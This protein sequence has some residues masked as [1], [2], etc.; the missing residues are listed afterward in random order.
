M[1]PALEGTCT[2]SQN[3]LSGLTVPIGG[4]YVFYY[5]AIS[6]EPMTSGNQVV[7]TIAIM[8]MIFHSTSK[9]RTVIY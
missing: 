5:I 3:V 7:A 8:L 4:T 1:S 2:V 9:I 6:R